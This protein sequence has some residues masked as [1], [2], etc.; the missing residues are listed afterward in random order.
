MSLF[1]TIIILDA[2]LPAMCPHGHRPRALQTKDLDATMDTYLVH[3][4]TLFRVLGSGAFDDSDG[5]EWR[6][7]GAVAIYER[8]SPV[9]AMTGARTVRAYGSCDACEPV[10]VRTD[11]PTIWGDI[12]DEHSLPVDFELTFRE[13][14][15]VQIT[16]T[17]GTRDDL[18][19]ELRQR[20][21]RVLGD[22][23]P[24][25]VAHRELKRARE[26]ATSASRHSGLR[27]R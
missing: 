5:A 24:L 12:V 20:G 14:E 6:I 22:D 1:D 7:E 4:G 23:E 3:N 18:K 2:D 26:H 11:G 21:L 9:E 17:T 8:R 13:G 16:R 25:A 10:L 27:H 19:G 15:P